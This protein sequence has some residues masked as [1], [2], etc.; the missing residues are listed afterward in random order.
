MKI[1]SNTK[2]LIALKSRGVDTEY[3][4]APIGRAHVGTVCNKDDNIGVVLNFDSSYIT[5]AVMAHEIGHNFGMNHDNS[6]CNCNNC[7]M[8]AVADLG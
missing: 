6:S 1:F 4:G 5:G 7:I 3:Y 2:A 8:S